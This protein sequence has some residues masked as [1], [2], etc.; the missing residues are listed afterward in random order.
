MCVRRL[1]FLAALAMVVW[2]SSPMAWA[3]IELR[4]PVSG[5]VVRT[6]QVGAAAWDPGHRG[7]DIASSPGAPVHASAAGMVRFAGSVAGRPVISIEHGPLRT[8][9]EPVLAVVSKGT[10]VKQ[11]Q[12]IG[13]LQANHPGCVQAACLHWGLTDGENYFDP[14][15]SLDTASGQVRLLP[16][17]DTT[18][19]DTGP[20]SLTWPAQ[21]NPGSGFGM[22]LHPILGIERMH[23]GTDIG[24]ACGS[25][26]LA[27]AA[28]KVVRREFNSGNGN[29]LVMAFTYHG[30]A[31]EVGFSHAS[32]YVV[33]VGDQV[34]AG[35]VVGSVG[36]TGLST[37]CHLHL[38]VRVSG[39]LVD[40][41]NWFT[42]PS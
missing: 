12:L 37:G 32:G 1:S 26:L 2:C 5:Q 23:W 34:L 41:M 15:A 33:D 27:P 24:A 31:V 8:T 10:A 36:S 4:Q 9:Y 17:S 14:L 7:V 42:A 16:D 28:A 20:A 35:Q 21:G 6:F 19:E 38:S 25:P 18:P 30:S 29:Y 39:E 3:N 22:R 13:Y 40:P 11:G